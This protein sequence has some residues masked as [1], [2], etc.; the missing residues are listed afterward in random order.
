MRLFSFCHSN[1]HIYLK[2]IL[3]SILW[4][5]LTDAA[6][7]ENG[8]LE[9]ETQAGNHVQ[10]QYEQGLRYLRGDGILQDEKKAFAWISRAALQGHTDAMFT[11]G[12]MYYYGQGVIADST[13][14]YEWHLRAAHND[15]IELLLPD[16]NSE[17]AEC[18]GYDW[19]GMVSQERHLA[20]KGGELWHYYEGLLREMDAG[21]AQAQ[22]CYGT[23]LLA[24][25]GDEALELRAR[26]RAFAW[27]RKAA[28]QGHSRA[29]NDLATL[30]RTGLNGID[31]NPEKALNWY[32]RSA[33]QGD[34]GGQFGAGMMNLGWFGLPENL[35]EAVY[36]LELA[37]EQKHVGALYQLGQMYE[38]GLGVEQN[39]LRAL[40]FYRQ[41]VEDGVYYPR[42]LAGA[43]AAYRAGLMYYYGLGIEPDDFE[44]FMMFEEAWGINY[45]YRVQEAAVYL[46][47][48]YL[49]GRGVPQ[50]TQTGVLFLQ[51]GAFGEVPAAMCMMKTIA[52]DVVEFI[53]MRSLNDESSAEPALSS[54]A[55]EYFDVGEEALASRVN[56]A[57]LLQA[58]PLPRVMPDDWCC[59]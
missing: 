4:I 30:Y 13:Q 54:M 2:F 11:L 46:G 7:A 48:M 21:N 9:H 19:S 58:C 37:A 52:P 23:M 43:Q 39:G 49:Q 27:L 56:V 17:P 1:G 24:M 41:A 12:E 10:A 47:V 32:L 33:K 3:L 25:Q 20:Q 14:A 34:A 6:K 35:K 28:L 38:E 18:E 51:E 15:L 5:F 8:G 53:L 59:F 29:Q 50:D 26:A 22:F 45:R 16:W 40:E 36:W 31:R 57:E 42:L 55:A 44:A